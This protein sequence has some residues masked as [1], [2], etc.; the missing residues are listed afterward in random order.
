MAGIYIHIPFCRQ[1]CTYCDF[2]SDTRTEQRGP[3]LKTL[4]HE[5][6]SRCSELA[7]HTVETLYIGGGTPSLYTPKDVN[8]LIQSIKEMFGVEIFEE[9][10]L[11]A[12]PDDLTDAYLEGLRKTPVNRLSLGVQS[13]DDRILQFFNRR[14]D[15]GDALEAVAR[16]KAHGYENLSVDLIYGIPGQSETGWAGDL[17]RFF[18]LDVP[19]LSAYHLTIE[20]GTPLGRRTKRGE[21]RPVADEVSEHHYEILREK[22][23][24]AGYLHYE[25]SNF[26]RPGHEAVHNSS[27]W[28][29]APYLGI[30]PSAHS[31]DGQR[32][33]RWNVSDNGRYLAAAAGDFFEEEALTDTDRFNEWLMTGLR[34][35]AGIDPEILTVRFGTEWVGEWLAAAEPF[36]DRGQLV[37]EGKNIRIPAEKFLLADTVISALFRT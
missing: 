2:H 22:A 26:A 14:H 28:S 12:N 6:G 33:R 13:F 10:T 29:G 5:M 17:D 21:L 35:A 3:M 16:A 15:S 36:F 37:R 1:R 18:T 34:T 23:A 8:L 4:L 9:L 7:G 24:E 11:E 30:G 25:I 19:H 32:R 20:E 27:Y 31:F